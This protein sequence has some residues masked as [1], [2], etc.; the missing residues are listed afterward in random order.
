MPDWDSLRAQLEPIVDEY[1]TQH[2][3]LTAAYNA[4]G[5]TLFASS[6]T[7]SPEA[8][9]EV[10][11][12]A[13]EEDAD[14]LE[15]EKELEALEASLEKVEGEIGVIDTECEE[16]LEA[17]EPRILAEVSNTIAQESGDEL[18]LDGEFGKVDEK[19]LDDEAKEIKEEIDK[20]VEKAV[21]GG[22]V[23]PL[24]NLNAREDL[25]VEFVPVKI[26]DVS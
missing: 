6:G 2:P 16:V 1:I 25:I 3:D 18:G 19:N 15:F 13:V 22:D 7:A 8:T 17:D 10:E 24:E 5:A 14:I 20:A 11:P 26:G 21:D 12:E 4:G 23:A 9:E